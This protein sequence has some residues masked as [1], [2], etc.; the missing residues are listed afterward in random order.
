MTGATLAA[1][2]A[3]ATLAGNTTAVSGSCS[4]G[5]GGGGCDNIHTRPCLPAPSAGTV[6]VMAYLNDGSAVAKSS[7]DG[8]VGIIFPP[9]S[10]SRRSARSVGLGG[11]RKDDEN[12]DN[13]GND[14]Y[15]SSINTVRN[16]N[17]RESFHIDRNSSSD[18]D[19]DS[20][21]SSAAD[22][23]CTMLL[24]SPRAADKQPGNTQLTAVC[25]RPRRGSSPIPARKQPTPPPPPANGRLRRYR[26]AASADRVASCGNEPLTD[27]HLATTREPPDSRK[28]RR[29]SK[30]PPASQPTPA[31]RSRER[32]KRIPL[33]PSS[34]A[35][36]VVTDLEARCRAAG[37]V[38]MRKLRTPRAST[39]A[40]QGGGP[41]SSGGS[42]SRFRRSTPLSSDGLGARTRNG[43]VSSAA[44][45]DVDTE[46]VSG[47]GTPNDDNHG[48]PAPRT[49][50]ALR[51]HAA[52][53]V[54]VSGVDPR[55]DGAG[56]ARPA[57]GIPAGHTANVTLPDPPAPATVTDSATSAFPSARTAPSWDT[58]VDHGTTSANPEGAT[59][60]TV[61]DPAGND[62][63]AADVRARLRPRR[64]LPQPAKDS[65]PRTVGGGVT[66]ASLIQRRGRAS[67]AAAT[68][69]VSPSNTD[70]VTEVTTS[71]TTSTMTNATTSV[72]SAA[73][74]FVRARVAPQQPLSPVVRRRR[75]QSQP[76][77]SSATA[78]AAAAT[79][80]ERRRDLAVGHLQ[81]IR[82]KRLL[83]AVTRQA[84][85]LRRL[86]QRTTAAAV[87]VDSDPTGI[88]PDAAVTS[89]RGRRRLP[90]L[91]RLVVSAD[92]PQAVPQATTSSG[93]I[94]HADAAATRTPDGS[95]T[96]DPGASPAATHLSNLPQHAVPANAAAAAASAAA[97]APDLVAMAGELLAT[98]QFDA[99]RKVGRG[100]LY[101]W[102]GGLYTLPELKMARAD[103]AMAVEPA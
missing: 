43:G 91:D 73:T 77:S 74:P 8:R 85:G 100:W 54:L 46:F 81:M 33:S 62:A 15:E 96:P 66:A 4:S 67:D 20:E 82:I 13:D 92:V 52:K 27:G 31:S 17:Y 24:Q 34:D 63:N 84:N 42:V 65:L 102:K 29:L 56:S 87:M 68:A 86:L 21:G 57:R 19:G 38:V 9:N 37:D 18:Q 26:T 75:R 90:Q 32:S 48:R 5:G 97:H 22:S 80:V 78:V 50:R 14:D 59:V 6:G 35:D 7:D 79:A 55:G 45:P 76:T 69:I 60:E 98:E 99:V 44:T 10:S 83:A 51:L 53:A 11:D 72:P 30:P 23:D 25:K 12:N 39:G 58:A 41:G 88:S 70:T 61:V 103:V 40:S 28:R 71:I 89:A 94:T 1:N 64:R 36:T 16:H 49:R 47:G 3:V 101:D 2:E 93:T 95:P